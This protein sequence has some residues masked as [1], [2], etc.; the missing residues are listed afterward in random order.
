MYA[1]PSSEVVTSDA[2]S[3]TSNY[4]PFLNWPWFG[5]MDVYLITRDTCFLLSSA[6]STGFSVLTFKLL[7][8]FLT[9]AFPV[10]FFFPYPPSFHGAALPG[11]LPI[12]NLTR[13]RPL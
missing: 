8:F 1:F 6:I 4:N 11:I 3:D 10:R 13:Q 12:L 9:F 5:W 7:L 2:I